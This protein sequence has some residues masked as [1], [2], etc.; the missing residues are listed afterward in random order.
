[1]GRRFLLLAAIFF[2]VQTGAAHAFTKTEHTL[3]MGDG[4]TLAAT[5]YTPPGSPP[6]GGWPAVLALHGLGENRSVTNGV[7]EAHLAPHDYVV[8]TVDARGHGASGGQCSLV[9]PR[10]LADYAAALQW[11]R[12]RPGVADA[13]VGAL[14]FSLGG[15]SVWKLLTAPGTRLAA[16]VP[17]TTWT[18]L[19]DALLPQGLV[20]SGLIAYFHNLLP[21]ERWDP[22]VT[23]LRD[24]ALQGRNDAAIREFAA[25]RSVRADLARI[26]TPVFMLQGRRDY[27]FDMQEALSAF[28]RLRGPKRIYLGGLGHA[29]SAN[30]AAEK[31]YYFGQIRMWFDRFLKGQLNGID[32]RPRIELAPD[33]WRPRT[34]QAAAPPARKV[35]RLK[36][37]GRR[38][39]DGLGGKV[40]RTVAPTRRLNE[41]FGHALV[42]VKASTPTGWSHLVAVLSALT[43]RGDEI[44]VSQG[45]IPTTTLRSTTRI[46]TIRLLSQATTIPR[47]SR[48]RLT[49]AGVSTAQNPNNLLYLAGPES[50]SRLALGEARIVLPV[51]R[52]PVSR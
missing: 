36:F 51:L 28:G 31:P 47:G 39:I 12:L 52:R 48:F 34:Y 23:A 13:R 6:P 30:P 43:P 20:K 14:G 4:V 8:L 22:A 46:L 5:L 37:R 35:L 11:L 41:T 26:R 24:D 32:R 19:Y 2:V 27:A 50:S 1:V 18:S 21:P 15:G 10:E 40:V 49:L 44:V 29:P 9:G 25:S 38:T 7:A 45:G 16:A 42:S 3:Q 33:P 17:V